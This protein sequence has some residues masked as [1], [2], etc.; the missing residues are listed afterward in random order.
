MNV[1]DGR[2]PG[3]VHLRVEPAADAGNLDQQD[4]GPG[5]E[6]ASSRGFNASLDWWKIRIDNTIIADTP[7]QIHRTATNRVSTRCSRFQRDPVTGIVTNLKFG[8]R[9]AG[10]MKPKATIWT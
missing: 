5:L 9:N 4:A 2:D 7:T 6:P 3:A 8:N 1:V 10:F